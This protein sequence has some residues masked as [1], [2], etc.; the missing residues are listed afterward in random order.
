MD[1]S[2]PPL[3]V[4]MAKL[5]IQTCLL[6]LHMLLPFIYKY[7]TLHLIYTPCC[8]LSITK[9]NGPFISGVN[10]GFIALNI[11][12]LKSLGI[13]RPC[14]IFPSTIFAIPTHSLFFINLTRL[15]TVEVSKTIMQCGKYNVRQAGIMHTHVRQS[16]HVHNNCDLSSEIGP[17]EFNTY[18]I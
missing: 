15:P 3:E 4:F 6:L 1:G 12:F 17:S 5:I 7:I 11:T 9:T 8:K 16:I 10:P 2:L 14:S 13:V 18:T